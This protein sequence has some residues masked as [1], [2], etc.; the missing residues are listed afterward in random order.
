MKR[1]ASLTIFFAV[2]LALTLPSFS[3]SAELKKICFIA[4]Q[5]G[6]FEQMGKDIS[7]SMGL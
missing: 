4:P 3:F 5:T 1:T 7:S 2:A 6:N